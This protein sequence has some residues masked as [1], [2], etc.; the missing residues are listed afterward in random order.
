MGYKTKPSLPIWSSVMGMRTKTLVVPIE[1]M[2]FQQSVP[3]L[4]LL[5]WDVCLCHP[6]EWLGR[7]ILNPSLEVRYVVQACRRGGLGTL[8]DLLACPSRKAPWRVENVGLNKCHGSRRCTVQHRT[9][10]AIGTSFNGPSLGKTDG[11][12]QAMFRAFILH[13]VDCK[14]RPSDGAGS[15]F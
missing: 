7:C 13:A 10:C 8:S 3:T 5:G 9:I 6:R 14:G 1:C 4:P 12:P 2:I 15:I 11:N